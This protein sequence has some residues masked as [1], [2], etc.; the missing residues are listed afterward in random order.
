MEISDFQ[1]FKAVFELALDGYEAALQEMPPKPRERYIRRNSGYTPLELEK[2][3]ADIVGNLR[4]GIPALFSAPSDEYLSIVNRYYD[5]LNNAF[6]K[7]SEKEKAELVSE[8]QE[9]GWDKYVSGIDVD[10]RAIVENEPKRLEHYLRG[11]IK[12]HLCQGKCE[13]LKTLIEAVKRRLD[14]RQLE[15]DDAVLIAY[16]RKALEFLK[17]FLPECGEQSAEPAVI[18][19]AADRPEPLPDVLQ[20]VKLHKDREKW[21]KSITGEDGEIQGR[22]YNK[23]R[24]SIE[25]AVALFCELYQC[26]ERE[27]ALNSAIKRAR[28][29]SKK[30][31]NPV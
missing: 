23:I 29:K 31:K 22:L 7:A 1:T 30:N 11:K 20:A 2:R 3:A 17:E 24:G 9:G 12:E 26:P 25:D 28:K 6:A 13:H 21:P 10:E 27:V 4:R 15:G 5:P 19:G 8:H 16:D 14:W 18:G